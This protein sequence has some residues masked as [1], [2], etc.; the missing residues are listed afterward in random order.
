ML[1][2][3]T[4]MVLLSLIIGLIAVKIRI[5]SVKKGRVKAGYF[6]LMEGSNTPDLIIKSTRCFNNLFEV[7]VLFYV[8]CTLYIS[9]GIE[10]LIGLYS[11]W[12][13][14]VARIAHAYVHLTYNNILHRMFVFWLGV[15]AILVLWGNLLYQYQ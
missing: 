13:F 8:V 1:Y 3:M 14:V 2:S 12:F 15:M 11:A 10:S 5:D 6:K 4:A 9:L 7:P